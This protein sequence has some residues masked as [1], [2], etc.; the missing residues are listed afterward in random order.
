[1]EERSVSG[2]LGEFSEDTLQK[3]EDRRIGYGSKTNRKTGRARFRMEARSVKVGEKKKKR[4]N[5]S[6]CE[7]FAAVLNVKSSP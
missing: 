1:M 2:L 3:D 4:E 5:T 6:C 7:C